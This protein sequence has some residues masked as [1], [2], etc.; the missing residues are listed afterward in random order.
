MRQIKKKPLF[1][2]TQDQLDAKILSGKHYQD[3]TTKQLK[4]VK[5]KLL[6]SQKYVCCYCECRVDKN[7]C[8]NEHFYEQDDYHIHQIHSLD[9][10]NNMIASCE[11][12]KDNIKDETTEEREE[13]IQ[14]TSCGH[15]KGKSYHNNIE[16][17]YKLLETLLFEQ[18]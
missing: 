2:P 5:T 9:Y 7:N 4:S 6:E 18:Q 1:K 16:V 12:D 3:I 11:G 15:K 13:R 14:N 8:H 10:V 17:D